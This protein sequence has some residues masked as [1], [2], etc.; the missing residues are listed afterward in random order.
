MMFIAVLQH[1]CTPAQEAMAC[2]QPLRYSLQQ[3]RAHVLQAIVKEAV[4]GGASC[5]LS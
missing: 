3:Y 1:Y 4:L 5:P 2:M